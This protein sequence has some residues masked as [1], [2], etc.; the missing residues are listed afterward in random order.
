MICLFIFLTVNIQAQGDGPRTHLPAPTGVWGVS[1]K[2]MNL[3]QNLLPTGN[4]FVPSADFSIN[5]VPTTLFHTFGI[6]GRPAL[7][8]FMVNPGSATA[9]LQTPNAPINPTR[10]ASASG[11]SD[12][13]VAFRLGLVG[14][15]A[16][17][18]NH[19]YDHPMVYNLHGYFRFW[20]SG[21]YDSGE[22]FNLGTNRFTIELGVPMAIPLN[23]NPK[24]ATWLEIYPSVQ[25]FTDNNDPARPT[26][27]KTEQAPLFLLENHFT[28]NLTPKFWVGADLR[29]QYGGL[30]S[31]DGVEDDNLINNLGAGISAG[32]LVFPFLDL[33]TTYGGIIAGQNDAESRMFRI[34]AIFSYVNMKKLNQ[35][36]VK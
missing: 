25:F 35:N 34:T 23:G 5:I 29:Y 17:D 28:H 3:Q 27:D 30:S 8:Q 19:F 18:L 1:A 6:Q 31:T 7:V 15:P 9:Q 14:T 32:Y 16:L 22:T 20:Y 26:A 21:T 12:G 10:E 4:F 36:A 11:L 13:F 33:N 2:Y 24:R